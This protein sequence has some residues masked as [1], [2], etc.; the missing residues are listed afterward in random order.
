MPD[1]PTYDGSMVLDDDAVFADWLN[2]MV[3]HGVSRGRRC[4][5]DPDFNLALASRIGAVRSTNFGGN[6]DIEAD[7]A[8]AGDALTD[9]TANAN[10]RLILTESA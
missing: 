10:R 5:V 3:G 4:P 1:L 9:S 6:C 8:M 7:V 2:N